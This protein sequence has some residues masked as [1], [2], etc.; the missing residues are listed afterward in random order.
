MLIRTSAPSRQLERMLEKR[1]WRRRLASRQPVVAV[2][3]QPADNVVSVVAAFELG[4]VQKL[5]RP[6]RAEK[7]ATRAPSLPRNIQ[8]QNVR[9]LEEE[10]VAPR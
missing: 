2:V 4:L 3:T 5:H 1:D 8:L 7:A 10:S 6:A 9:H